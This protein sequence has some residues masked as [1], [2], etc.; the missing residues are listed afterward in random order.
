MPARHCV[1]NGG[2]RIASLDQEDLSTILALRRKYA[3][4][5]MDF[6][7][8]SLVVVALRDRRETGE[9]IR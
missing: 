1:V 5:P 8:A 3:D 6:A 2:L 4:R 9:K 7:D